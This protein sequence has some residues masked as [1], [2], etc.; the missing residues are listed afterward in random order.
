LW[1]ANNKLKFNDYKTDAL[2][3]T[4]SFLKT[5]PNQSALPVGDHL[6]KTS[7][8]VRNLG[9]VMDTHL[10]MDPHIKQS[11]KKAFYHLSRITRI[12]KAPKAGGS[13][14]AGPF[15]RDVPA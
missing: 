6:I 3:I 4:S 2:L 8:A 12:K 15:F 5:K 13:Q 9:L 7:D 10:T 11:C 1:A 14:S